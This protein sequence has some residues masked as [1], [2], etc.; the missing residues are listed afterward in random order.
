M[1]LRCCQE[2]SPHKSHCAPSPITTPK[3]T[4][5][6]RS[7]CCC[8]AAV[9]LLCCGSVLG[10][11]A[12]VRR[13]EHHHIIVTLGPRHHGTCGKYA[14]ISQHQC[15]RE[16][17]G[18]RE[19]GGGEETLLQIS[20]LPPTAVRTYSTLGANPLKRWPRLLHGRWRPRKEAP[21]R[22]A[23]HTKK[24]SNRWSTVSRWAQLAKNGAMECG[25]TAMTREIHSYWPPVVVPE[26][27]RPCDIVL[28][29]LVRI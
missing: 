29:C 19:G 22:E 15:L 8:A 2:H 21:V 11:R 16:T 23:R 3:Q 13:R 5:P 27:P 14:L 25:R 12:G 18:E 28:S 26:G 1:G 6:P 10:F 9:L 24:T 4:G 20:E 7:C 17:T